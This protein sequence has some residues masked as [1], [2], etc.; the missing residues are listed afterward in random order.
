MA[1]SYDD[2]HSVTRISTDRLNSPVVFQDASGSELPVQRQGICGR[3]VGE[4]VL[5][6][7]SSAG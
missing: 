2:Q 1:G 4:D 7:E 3:G 5:S 6:F